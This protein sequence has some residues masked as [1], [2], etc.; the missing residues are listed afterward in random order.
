MK[1]EFADQDCMTNLLRKHLPLAV[2]IAGVLVVGA[3][4]AEAQWSVRVDEGKTPKDMFVV[5]D[6]RRNL[7]DCLFQPFTTQEWEAS[8]FAPAADA[9]HFQDLR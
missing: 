7:P 1:E 4:L 9:A 2:Y 5:D 8:N 6:P 3:P